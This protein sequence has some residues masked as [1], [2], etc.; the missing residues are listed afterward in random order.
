[1]AEPFL[2]VEGLSKAYGGR[3][4]LRRAGLTLEKGR[5]L[6]L[7]GMSG[8]GKSTLARCLAGFERPDEGTMVLDGAALGGHAAEPPVQLIFQEAA[9]SLNPR[10]T[11]EEIVAE[12]LVIRR[13]GTAAWRRKAA[14]EW[15][16]MVGISRAAAAKPALA[17]S[18]GERQRLAMARALAAEPK[19]L[20]V[21]E[22]LSGLDVMLQAQIGGLLAD[23][24]RRLELTCILITHDLGLAGR[25]ADEIA[26]MDAGEI[27]EQA[28]AG[29]VMAAPAHARTRELLEAG[30]VLALP[31]SGPGMPRTYGERQTGGG[32]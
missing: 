16:E 18:G 29:Q 20:I 31:P 8:S 30:R 7:V 17:S 4:A 19:L 28:P 21:D 3:A 12:P 25:L 14:G 9:A 27:V 15:L 32:A 26:V 13:G 11:A 6:G 5:M 24:R 1:M 23:L 10:F 22:T 2:R